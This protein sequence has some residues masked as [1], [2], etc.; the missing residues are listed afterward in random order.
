MNKLIVFTQKSTG[1][2]RCKTLKETPRVLS[3]YI[4]S[5]CGRYGRYRYPRSSGATDP[6]PQIRYNA[7]PELLS[8][9]QNFGPIWIRIQG[10]VLNFEEK[11]KLKIIFEKTNFVLNIFFIIIKKIMVPEEFLF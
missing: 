7:D 3:T 8:G 1:S 5:D 10:Y 9:I 11:T 2:R 4:W 6:N